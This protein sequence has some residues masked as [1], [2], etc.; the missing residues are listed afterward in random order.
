[1]VAHPI[2]VIFDLFRIQL[3]HWISPVVPCVPPTVLPLCSGMRLK[4]CSTPL[5][6]KAPED[7][8][9]SYLSGGFLDW[10]GLF[11]TIKKPACGRLLVG[12]SY[13][14]LI[15]RNRL[16]QM[17]PQRSANRQQGKRII[18]PVQA[19]HRSTAPCALDGAQDTK[20]HHLCPARIPPK[21][22]TPSQQQH[23]IAPAVQCRPP[24]YPA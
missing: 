19:P 5:D 7:P 8:G 18:C 13:L 17:R 12:D 6:R 1:M 21:S 3:T 4:W 20:P 11:R 10:I 23:R 15:N 9:I 22:R 2:C 16:Q 24:E 14:F